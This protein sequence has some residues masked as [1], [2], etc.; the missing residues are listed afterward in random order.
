[1][2]INCIPWVRIFYRYSFLLLTLPRFGLWE[3]LHVGSWVFLT[4][5]HHF[6]STSLSSDTTVYSGLIFIFFASAF[7]STISP[8]HPGSLYWIVI[9]RNQDLHARCAHCYW[10]V[11]ACRLFS[12]TELGNTCIYTHT[13]IYTFISIYTSVCICIKISE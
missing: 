1:M 10:S 13:C 5:L 2:D 8:R 6:M 3:L 12:L 11:F 4:C 9:F 7:Q